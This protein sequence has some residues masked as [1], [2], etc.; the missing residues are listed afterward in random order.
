MLTI[1]YEPVFSLTRGEVV[2]SIHHG[3]ICVVSSTGDCLA[4]Y[5]SSQALT[6]LRSSA[7]PFQALPLIERQGHIHYGFLPHEIAITCA[8]HSG[9]D[10]HV[11]VIESIQ[12]KVGI[13]ESHLLCGVHYPEHQE[14]ANRLRALGLSPTP[15]R[16]NCSGKHSGML[17]LVGLMQITDPGITYIQPDHPVQKIILQTFAEMCQLTPS[18]I[19]VAIDGCSVPNF[20]I[21]LY[22]AALAYARIC[23]PEGGM[24]EPAIRITACHTIV[25]SMIAHPTMVAGPGRFDTRLM[26]VGAG[27]WVSKGGA[28]GYQGIGVKPGVLFH[29]SPG[30]GIAVKIADGDLRNKI[31]G[32]VALEILSQLGLLSKED[33][34]DLMDFG[35]TFPVYNLRKI[36]VGEGSPLFTLERKTFPETAQWSLEN[37][38][39]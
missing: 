17:A 12:K 33:M 36:K 27:R 21:P 16:H 15:N 1:P 22:N 7:K 6:F 35:P 18:E 26:E 31:R 10:E 3:A 4:S 34:V 2:E 28:E 25:D 29:G 38:L 23:D 24:V 5:G 8:S 30:L 37:T 32:A 11:A 14:T 13:N 19:A 20:A 9:T 39:N